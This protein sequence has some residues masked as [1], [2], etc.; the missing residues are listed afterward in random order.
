MHNKI[1]KNASWIIGTKIVQALFNLLI[2]MLTARYLG[3]SN[4]GSINYAAAIVAFATPF[5][6]L[7]F[8]SIMVQE[9][10][11]EQDDE[12]MVLGTS[13]VSCF[14]SSIFCFIGIFAFLMVANRNEFETIAVCMLYSLV[15][16]VGCFDVLSYWFQAKL[17]S[18]YYSLIS[19]FAFVITSLF[20][21]YLLI[22]EKSIYWF[23][24]SYT[25]DYSIIA[26]LA[27]ITYKKLNGNRFT[28]NHNCFKRMIHRSK[29]YIISELMIVVFTQTDRIMLNLMIDEAATGLYSSAVV[30]AGITTFVFTA[31]IDSF[32]PL[33][34]QSKKV[35][36]ESFEHNVCSLYSVIIYLSILQCI[37]IV[38]F[39]KLI[40]DIIYGSEFSGAITILKILAWYTAFSYLGAVRNIWILAENKQNI[41]WRIDLSGAIANVFLNILLIPILGVNG[42]AIASLVT[43][44]FTNVIMVFIIKDVRENIRFMVRSLSPNYI[45]ELFKLSF[46]KKSIIRR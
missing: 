10:I 29:Y 25:I 23:A 7:G 1:F 39:A 46:F 44:I 35:S 22:A 11:S 20:K 9:I 33:I 3:P 36:K 21:A 41:I 5:M 19:L 30:C 42:A 28:F 43:Q 12:G 27:I 13:I 16:V 14:I 4:F 17:K 34:F 8:T 15:L 2:T 26:V 18:K 45:V 32:R 24:I 37:F 31:I 40:V 6:H 38:I